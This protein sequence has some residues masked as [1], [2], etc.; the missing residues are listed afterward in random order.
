MWP[1]SLIILVVAATALIVPRLVDGDD[2]VGFLDMVRG[3]QVV[4]SEGDADEANAG[5]THKIR[6]ADNGQYMTEARLNGRFLDML[7]D[8]GA[9]AVAL[10]ESQARKIGI[11]LQPSDYNLPVQTANGATHGAR[12]VIRELKLGSIRL[13]NI[14]VIVL[15]DEALSVPLLGMSAL[16][17]L[18]GFD[19]S[20][21]TM[22]LVQ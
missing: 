22:I 5:R 11:F 13:K 14:D 16:G 20:N 21:D 18:R 12:S 2:V 4:S 6:A 15:K 9:S 1:V 3:G 10:P 7:V 17:R 8:T 19:I